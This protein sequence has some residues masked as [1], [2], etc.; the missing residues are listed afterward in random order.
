MNINRYEIFT[1]VIN[2][3][4][5]YERGELSTGK[6][7]E[8]S[9][10][11]IYGDEFILKAENNLWDAITY[12]LPRNLNYN[13]SHG[14]IN[15]SWS[16]DYEGL[17]PEY[18]QIAFN[19]G[20]I[21]YISGEE[22]HYSFD[23]NSEEFGY[24]MFAV[25]KDKTILI[26]GY[27][28]EVS[29]IHLDL[30]IA[31]LAPINFGYTI[32]NNNNVRLTWSMNPQGLTPS[33]YSIQRNNATIATLSGSTLHYTDQG[34]VVGNYTYR[35]FAHYSTGEVLEA[36]NTLN[37]TITKPKIQPTNFAYT[38]QNENNV[39]LTWSMSSQGLT[40]SSYKISRNGTI[41]ATVSGNTLTYTD[42]ELEPGTYTYRLF[43]HYSAWEVLEAGNQITLT[44][45]P[46]TY[47]EPKYLSYDMDNRDVVLFWDIFS[48]DIEPSSYK[49]ERNGN[50]IAD[51][52]SEISVYYD[53]TAGLGTHYYR[54]FAYYG[55]NT[56]KIIPEDSLEV[57]IP[58]FWEPIITG[59]NIVFSQHIVFNVEPVFQLSHTSGD[60][61]VSLT[62]E[63]L[64][65]S[66]VVDHY[67]IERNGNSLFQVD[68]NTLS[69]IDAGLEFGTY[70]YTVKAY[71]TNDSF[72]NHV[73][74]IVGR[75]V[76]TLFS[77]E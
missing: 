42:Q 60:N 12:C 71:Y 45:D 46:L 58:E 8:Y 37:V 36:G 70:E 3:F 74:R 28:G 56:I 66:N 62:W 50:F 63:M 19:G 72:L 7:Y 29:G 34:L 15:F 25:Y 64:E 16:Y 61:S 6:L 57:I 2:F 26:V 52:S 55:D 51:V 49:I 41:I 47:A 10:Y 65:G 77:C 35:L 22:T 17:L 18:Y 68:G 4:S 24:R 39:K 1:P 23:L 20:E 53:T 75:V 69:F 44:I 33:Y 76:L 30:V 48:G 43:A 59:E 13:I 32:Q 67:K 38:L 11:A 9:L 31:P 40:P 73:A 54:L 5:D 21:D 14:T 27:E